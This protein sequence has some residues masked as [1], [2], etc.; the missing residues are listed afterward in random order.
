M[1]TGNSELLQ[2]HG[3]HPDFDTIFPKNWTRAG[4]RKTGENLGNLGGTQMLWEMGGGAHF[5]IRPNWRETNG[6]TPML[7]V[8]AKKIT[9]ITTSRQWS[10]LM[11]KQPCQ[12]QN[13]Y[14]QL[15][16]WSLGSTGGKRE[17][18]GLYRNS[19]LYFIK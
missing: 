1:G 19:L 12:N 8:W 18:R 10:V 9:I 3:S 5:P 13:S 16:A 6:E 17:V 14:K 2:S 4:V 11:T 15:Y 7:P